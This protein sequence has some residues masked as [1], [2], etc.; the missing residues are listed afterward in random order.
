MLSFNPQVTSYPT[1][2]YFPPT[3]PQAPATPAPAPTPT[4][5]PPAH[6]YQRKGLSPEA[7]LDLARMIKHPIQTV[8]SLFIVSKDLLGLQGQRGLS[9]A[10]ADPALQ[11]YQVAKA[12]VDAAPFKHIFPFFDRALDRWADAR[13]QELKP[14]VEA[15]VSDRA[16]HP[17]KLHWPDGGTG[18]ERLSELTMFKDVAATATDGQIVRAFQGL[19]HI[20]VANS[21]AM[22]YFY[23]V[24]RA[25]DA[26]ILRRNLPLV[27]G[28]KPL[29]ETLQALLQD[30]ASVQVQ[31][32]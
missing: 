8:K 3:P 19:N 20:R 30:A 1:T 29:P 2:G 7:A 4:P 9:I 26:L 24:A 18:H 21:S 11:K 27:P 10:T 23:P 17:I 12:N 31:I 32:L 6:Y 14:Q 15:Q 28:Q 16:W 5:T 25:G 13:F 22:D